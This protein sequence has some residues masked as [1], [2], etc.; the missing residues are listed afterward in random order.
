[1]GLFSVWSGETSVILLYLL[2]PWSG[3]L[4]KEANRFSASQEIPSIL[5]KQIFHYRHHKCSPAFPIKYQSRSESFC[6]NIL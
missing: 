5:W 6:M 2:A 1:M 3:V 4:L